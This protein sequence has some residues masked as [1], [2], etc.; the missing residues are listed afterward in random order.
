VILYNYT[1]YTNYEE[2]AAT[3]L[4]MLLLG[5]LGLPMPSGTGVPA[6]AFQ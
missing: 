3:S 6:P 2:A 1:Q 5:L 4:A